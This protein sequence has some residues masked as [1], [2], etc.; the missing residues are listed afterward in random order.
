MLF[1]CLLDV[2]VYY[3]TVLMIAHP[4]QNVNT[5]YAYFSHFL[6][7]HATSPLLLYIIKSSYS[8]LPCP[9][10]LLPKPEILCYNKNVQ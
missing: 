5:F 4:L 2:F 3:L 10:F 1:Y 7:N 8:I 6:Q 9:Y